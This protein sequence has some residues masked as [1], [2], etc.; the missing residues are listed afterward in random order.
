LHAASWRASG[1]KIPPPT[2][3]HAP[4]LPARHRATVGVSDEFPQSAFSWR[5]APAAKPIRED[6]KMN[7]EIRR[8]L[9]RAARALDFARAHPVADAGFGMV[10]DR[11]ATVVARGDTL[12]AAAT[13]GQQDEQSALMQRGSLKMAIRRNY[14]DRLAKIADMAADAHPGLRGKFIIPNW[15]MPNKPFVVAT[16]SLLVAAIEQKDLFTSLGLG[17]TFIAD[18]TAAINAFASST[19]TA[20][21]GRSNHIA[22]NSEFY[23]VVRA[24]RREVDLL[25]TFYRATLA[26][27]SEVLVAWRSARNLQ[28]PYTHPGVQPAPAPDPL[29]PPAPVVAPVI[30]PAPAS[31]LRMSATVN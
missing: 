19:L 16:Q 12:M 11:L 26:E 15:D 13:A 6:S 1:K 10:V 2:V 9:S 18:L 8:K 23:N 3:W 29:A 20:H 21:G 28:G 31:A 25:S 5:G 27:N 4:C 22:A 24:M 30:D 7:A 17:D 14:L